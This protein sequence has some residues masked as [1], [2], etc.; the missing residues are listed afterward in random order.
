LRG[1]DLPIL[2]G[3]EIRIIF[4]QV[5]RPVNRLTDRVAQNHM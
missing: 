2:P 1:A 3:G 4:R 5:A